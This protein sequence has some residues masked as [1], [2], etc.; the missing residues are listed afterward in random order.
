MDF[1]IAP[2]LTIDVVPVGMS[3]EPVLVIDDVLQSPEALRGVA[4][5][6]RP[7]RAMPP[8]S[9]PGLR[10][11]L[12]G[13][14]ARGLIA[15]LHGP[16]VDKLL[17]GVAMRVVRFECSFSMVTLSPA[18]LAPLQRVPHI[19]IARP[20]RVAIM[21]FLCGPPFGGTAFYRQ[22]ETGLEQV[23]PE[24][25]DRY[26]AARTAGLSKLRPA[27]GYP[28][29]ELPGYVR[30]AAV[31]ARFNRVLA[32]RS[33]TLHSGVIEDA[34]LLSPDPATGRLVTTFFVDYAPA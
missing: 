34:S 20:D 15:R 21:H 19:D 14:Y 10:A 26:I 11:G 23:G 13:T 5:A 8:G 1:A 33:C 28:G 29:A 30:T 3:R 25:R 27:D 31:A 6:V 2:A 32:Y 22:V 7:W 4:C 12:P 18:E 24:T 17:G 9:F 16:I